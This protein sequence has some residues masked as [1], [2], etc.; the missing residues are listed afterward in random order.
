M[1][2]GLIFTAYGFIA[3]IAGPA[4][5]G[6]VLDFTGDSYL[7]VFTYLAIFCLL[8]AFLVMLAKSKPKTAAPAASEQVVERTTKQVAESAN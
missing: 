6:F 3:G 1:I 7:A 2:F 5:A 4:L 8:A